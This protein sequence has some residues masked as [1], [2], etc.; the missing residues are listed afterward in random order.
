MYKRQ[1]G[2]SL[3]GLVEGEEVSFTV[4]GSQTET[5]SSTNTYNIDWKDVIPENYTITES[6]GTLTVTPVPVTPEEPGE[7]GEPTPGPGD[8]PTEDPG[9]TTTVTTIP[10]EATPLAAAGD[11]LGARR[12]VEADGGSVLGASRVKAVL[13]ARRGAQTADENAMAMYMAMMGISA[14]FAGL[15]TI[16]RRKKRSAKNQ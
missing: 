15:Y 12:G 4:T 10:D 9:E 6:L 8:G 7:P 2:G 13:G 11:V 16:A 14:S 1:A 3:T 5:G